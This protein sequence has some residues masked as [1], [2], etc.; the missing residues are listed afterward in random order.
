MRNSFKNTG[1]DASDTPA[2]PQCGGG[3]ISRSL[4]A[5]AAALMTTDR[6]NDW[7]VLQT[8]LDSFRR[9]AK[10]QLRLTCVGRRPNL[11]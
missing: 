11:D 8:P 7:S 9:W 2:A 5:L 6:D 3:A 4:S 1:V 10:A